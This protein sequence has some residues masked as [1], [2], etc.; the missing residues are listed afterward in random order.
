MATVPIFAPD[1]T[2]GDIPAEQLAAAVKAGARPGVHVSAPD[3]TPGVIPADKTQDAVKQGARVEPFQQ[4][5]TKSWLSEAG[6]AMWNDIKAIPGALAA[7]D[8][9][10]DPTVS[11]ADKWKIYEKQSAAAQ[12]KSDQRTNE[13]GL[14]Y[15]LGATVNEML[16]VNVEGEEQAAKK[17]NPGAVIGHAATVPALMA[18]GMLGEVAVENGAPVIKSVSPYAAPIAHRLWKTV[19]TLT[20]DRIGKI[21]DAWKTLPEEIR[22][23]GPQF[24][25]P[26]APLPETPP[27]ELFQARA[28]AKGAE[29]EPAAALGSIPNSYVRPAP[30]LPAA[31]QPRTAITP[32]IGTVDNPFRSAAPQPAAAAPGAAGSMVDSVALPAA[33]VAPSGAGIPR[34]LNGESILGQVLGGRDQATLLKI[35][36][37]RGINVTQEAQLKP[38]IANKRIIGKIIGDFSPEELDEIRAQGIENARFRHA[39]GDIGEE[40]WN[41]MALQTYF[42]DVKIPLAQV[43]RTQKAIQ[44]AAAPKFAP[45]TDLAA[46]L[47]E[48]AAAP[49]APKA[50]AATVKT[51]NEGED[52][53]SQWDANNQFLKARK[54]SKLQDLR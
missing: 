49:V 40:A 24:K 8:L 51:L 42:P 37:S 48:S 4:Q 14:P 20:F 3:G 54:V 47:K 30:E 1:G 12:A 43:M 27:A 44:S 16:G 21:W 19:D 9:L 18:A 41:T 28:L 39:F 5:P 23:K 10:A 29:A 6:S 2:L 52:L 22:A 34:T 17:G 35:A 45:T 15:S 46:Q 36:R 33:Q 53:T 38:G 11:D 26:G 25:D 32:P 13:R 7:P 50:K 31:F